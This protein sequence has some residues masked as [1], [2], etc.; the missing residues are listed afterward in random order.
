MPFRSACRAVLTVVAVVSAAVPA[1]AAGGPASGALR[2]AP[3]SARS[4]VGAAR[5]ARLGHQVCTTIRELKGVDTTVRPV[6][7]ADSRA[8]YLAAGDGVVVLRR[9]GTGRLAFDSCRPVSGPCGAQDDGNLVSEMVLGPG[10]HELYV[11]LQRQR[12]GG[13][14]ISGFPVGAG[15]R[16][17]DA[18][19]CLLRAAVGQYQELANPRGCRVDTGEDRAQ[20]S[21]LVLT[22]DGRFAYVISDGPA[23]VGV[24]ELTR[25]PDGSLAPGA[26]CISSDG[27]RGFQTPGV[28][29]NLFPK[30]P[31]GLSVNLKQ[32]A[33]TPDGQSLIALGQTPA[34]RPGRFDEEEGTVLRLAIDATGGLSRGPAPT[35][36]ISHTGLNGCAA[37]AAMFGTEERIAVAGNR[38]YVPATSTVDN[39]RGTNES[40]VLGFVLAAGGGLVLPGR[41]AGCVGARTEMYRRIRGL[42]SCSLGR[43][44]LHN[45]LDLVVGPGGHSLYTAGGVG[46]DVIATSLLRLGANGAPRAVQ[47]PAGCLG[48][49]GMRERTPCSL[50]RAPEALNDAGTTLAFTPDGRAAY[51]LTAVGDNVARLSVLQRT[52]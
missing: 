15:D 39:G 6:V 41:A 3:L 47:G 9:D 45:I 7:A 27:T 4:C 13:A 43:Q 50:P 35:A 33:V 21:G 48:T 26:G 20:T 46:S 1:G 23:T 25:G 22:P 38:V 16:L 17:G 5:V 31:P 18:P 52:R 36:C 32:L 14:E 24:A 40:A 2:Q 10:G 30:I 8:I 19:A 51:V 11:V 28:C 37:S 34:D 29:A 42:G 12:D 44:T 49:Y